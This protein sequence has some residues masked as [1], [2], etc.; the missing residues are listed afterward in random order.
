MSGAA[1]FL[2]ELPSQGYFSSS[3]PSSNPGGMRVYICDHETAPPEEQLIRTDST[4]ILI[5]YL[6]LK[7][8]KTEQKPKD[9]KRKAEDG[10]AKR[11]A[12]RPCD[13]KV[14][15]KRIN[16]G[17]APSNSRREG[18]SGRLSDKELQSFTVQKIK[19]LLKERGQPL[20]GNK[21]EL[22]ARLKKSFS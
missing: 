12:E 13:D 9:N 6:T 7:K 22:I 18:G 16:I 15:T 17:G 3:Q 8:G 5:R 21:D 20:K 4:N 11:S 1:Q 14:M 2:Q 10:K 19:A